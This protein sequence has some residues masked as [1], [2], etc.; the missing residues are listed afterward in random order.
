MILSVEIIRS[1]S[2]LIGI[3][4]H[5]IKATKVCCFEASKELRV[6]NRVK[7]RTEDR[8]LFLLHSIRFD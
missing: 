1:L 5:D 8:L 7:K 3:E 2:R 6:W 4:S